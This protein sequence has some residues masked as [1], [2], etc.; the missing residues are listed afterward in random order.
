VGRRPVGKPPNDP[1]D[2]PPT[3]PKRITSKFQWTEPPVKAAR[4]IVVFLSHFCEGVVL[5]GGIK[6]FQLYL[7]RIG[8]LDENLFDQYPIRY[9]IDLLD[10]GIFGAFVIWGVV[11]FFRAHSAQEED[12]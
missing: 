2:A 9:L 11:D 12:A 8:L 6:L 5:A 3:R 10:A 4:G 1:S 7:S